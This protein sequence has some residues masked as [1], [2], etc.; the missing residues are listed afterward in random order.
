MRNTTDTFG[1]SKLVQVAT[2]DQLIIMRWPG[3]DLVC[4]DKQ[5]GI[6]K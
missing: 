5:T 1:V 4:P 2:S 3:F 6:Y